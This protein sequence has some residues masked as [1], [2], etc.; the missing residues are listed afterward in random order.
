MVVLNGSALHNPHRE[1]DMT[2]LCFTLMLILTLTGLA[3]AQ[4]TTVQSFTP[5]HT[6]FSETPFGWLTNP[7]LIG[8]TRGSHEFGFAN[9]NSKKHFGV[10]EGLA[11][12]VP[13]FGLSW[14]TS[15]QG[16]RLTSWTL[17]FGGAAGKHLLW[18][19]NYRWFNGEPAQFRTYNRWSFGLA[20]RPA[21]FLALGWVTDDFNR[22]KIGDFVTPRTH[23]ASAAIRVTPRFILEASATL[24]DSQRAKEIKPR[25]SAQVEPINGLFLSGS[26]QQHGMIQAGLGLSFG[27]GRLGYST[28]MD[29]DGN[30]LGG[31]LVLQSSMWKERT[32]LESRRR[33]V[34]YELEGDCT[35]ERAG[36]SLFSSRGP[37]L[38]GIL[39]DLHE[40]ADDPTVEG[41]LI[42][43]EGF[44]A[45][46]AQ[47]EEIRQAII[48]LRAA[49]KRTL[50]YG[51]FLDNG[52]Y[53][54]ATACDHIWTMPSG[55]VNLTGL[56]STS[57]FLRGMLDKLGISPDLEH[58]GDYK[59][60]SDMFTRSD[61]T[62]AQ[63]EATQ[64]IL[65]DS[66]S[67]W[68]NA[69]A[70]GRKVTADSMTRIVNGGPWECSEA[71]A[72]GL[73]DSLVFP[74][75][76]EKALD[77]TFDGPQLA[78]E[79]YLRTPWRDDRWTPKPKIAIVMAEGMIEDGT[80]GSGLLGKVMGGKT[81]SKAIRRA[82]DNPMI[83]GIVLR[84]NSGGGSGT[85]SDEIWQAVN[86]ARHE[87]NKPVVVSMGNVAGSGGYYIACNADSIF[88]DA[89]TITGSIG[90]ISGKFAIRG[91]L[92]KIGVN[93]VQLKKS[94]HAGFGS[95]IDTFSVG[96]RQRLKKQ[97]DI[98]YKDFVQKVAD[99]RHK[100]W[101][102]IHKLAQ[103]RI[104]SG[105]RGAQNGLVDRVAGMME[106]ITVCKKMSGLA[107]DEEVA[108]LEYPHQ[109]SL[110]VG[111]Q[112]LTGVFTSPQ[113][114]AEMAEVQKLAR[115]F[116]LESAGLLLSNEPVLY[117]MP[118]QVGI[119]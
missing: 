108:F 66:W 82:A 76:V 107:A 83:R 55:E 67:I 49:G 31:G 94:D 39:T 113:S 63:R 15:L 12:R 65:D 115:V 86:Y 34:T 56:G 10:A 79:R 21:E 23:T 72:A 28:T 4:S 93:A 100:D 33:W 48:D 17:G 96:E 43:E 85:A 54:L 13:G 41:V 25:I 46:M 101:D 92:D 61:M 51:K 71:L 26:W 59:S 105:T 3:F 37:T 29:K 14:E 24:A 69:L 40:L 58:I 30:Y 52:S 118:Y 32:F 97:L 112:M 44:A 11:M 70:Q 2:R 89:T 42:Q 8:D 16:E 114:T 64:A 95:M 68:L 75:E 78:G 19:F 22:D 87:K 20:L 103:G 18:G 110:E 104:W 98:F 80:S 91:L 38:H 35:E 53:Y 84:I 116:G 6:L 88:A 50:Y 5:Q 73:V 7:A 102:S 109:S 60:A 47:R 27:Q 77:K 62:P 111:V 81:I 99:G 90:V 36:F 117:L 9:L 119:E 57:L 74:D 106:A 1:N 45:G